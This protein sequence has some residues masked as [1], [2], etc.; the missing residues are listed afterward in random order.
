M[1]TTTNPFGIAD[2]R[3][4][5][6][7]GH[8]LSTQDWE[9]LRE[10]VDSC[11]LT[12]W[13]LAATICEALDWTRPNGNLKTREC[14]EFLDTLDQLGVMRLPA[15][16][17]H[18]PRG[19]TR[20]GLTAAGEERPVREGQVSEVA[21]VALGL[22]GDAEQRALWR[23][24]V[25]RY[26]YLGH[27]VPYG[28]H[29]RY[30]IWISKP[31]RE[32]AGCLQ[33]SSPAWKLDARDRWLGWDEATRRANLQKIVNNSRFLL[34][35]WLR[36]HGLASHVL[37]QAARV[38][39]DDWE[40]AYAVR[41]VAIETFVETAR[42]DGTCYKAANW[43]ELGQTAGRGRMDRTGASAEPVKTCFLYPLVGEYR[44]Q[45]GVVGT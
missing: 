5:A 44:R 25:E 43:I 20:V 37:S 27:K 38:V 36:I 19:R 15:V 1:S 13:E 21:P 2:A 9:T 28:A 31:T 30:L 24:L 11:G 22:V 4:P 41:P 29:L 8:R 45:L 7:C 12:R 18:R 6:F 40:E 16:Q 26:H 33:F 34:V 23:E 10:I 35:P 39:V 3:L 17:S 32:V 42:F 14:F